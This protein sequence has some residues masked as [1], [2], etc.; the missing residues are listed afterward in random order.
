MQ[1]PP[2]LSLLSE[3]NFLGRNFFRRK[4][5]VPDECPTTALGRMPH[6]SRRSIIAICKAV[7]RVTATVTSIITSLV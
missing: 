4:A 3:H 6:D 2:L 5:D 7:Q 1:L